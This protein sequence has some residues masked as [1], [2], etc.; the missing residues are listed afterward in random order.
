[1]SL[2]CGM[3]SWIV[4]GDADDVDLGVARDLALHRFERHQH[5]LVHILSEGAHALG[6]EN[7]DHLAT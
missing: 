5:E 3:S 1:M 2:T 6:L 7:A 4:D